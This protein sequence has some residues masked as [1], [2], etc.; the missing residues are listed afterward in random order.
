MAIILETYNVK[1]IGNSNVT[2]FRLLIGWRRYSYDDLLGRIWL[3]T[4]V[5][6]RQALVRVKPVILQTDSVTPFMIL[7]NIRSAWN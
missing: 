1:F 2:H 6:S 5:I 7:R 3:V 4:Q